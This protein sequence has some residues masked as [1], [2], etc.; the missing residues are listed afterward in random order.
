MFRATFH[1]VF[2]AMLSA[3]CAFVGCKRHSPERLRIPAKSAFGQYLLP[4]TITSPAPA[5]PKAPTMRPSAP[6]S[7]YG[8]PHVHAHHEVVHQVLHDAVLRSSAGAEPHDP[9]LPHDARHPTIREA[10][11][12]LLLGHRE[13]PTAHNLNAPAREREQGTLQPSEALQQDA[14]DD[15][16][17]TP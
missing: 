15:E 17:P 9:S 1:L 2:I 10:G 11:I 13:H 6:V 3:L 4:A 8:A 7:M 16:G 5:K 12:R 14:L